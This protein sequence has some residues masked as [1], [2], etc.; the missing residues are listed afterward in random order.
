MMGSFATKASMSRKSSPHEAEE[1][2]RIHISGWL[3]GSCWPPKSRARM[4]VEIVA[5]SE[6]EPR[7]SIR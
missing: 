4:K 7:K 2:I 5:A 6:A 1:R 3:Q